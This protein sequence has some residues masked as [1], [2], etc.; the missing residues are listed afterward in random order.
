MRPIVTHNA[1]DVA[2]VDLA[3]T[4]LMGSS[5]SRGR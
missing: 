4:D 5:V 2:R 1:R 3:V